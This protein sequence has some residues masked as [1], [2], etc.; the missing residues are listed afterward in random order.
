MKPG[1]RTYHDA[2]LHVRA[3]ELVSPRLRDGLREVTDIYTPPAARRQGQA[4]TLLASVC[5][6][7]DGMG[8]TLLIAVIGTEDASTDDL[9]G[10]YRRHGFHYLQLE[11]V[12]LMTRP[13]LIAQRAQGLL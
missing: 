6:E 9:C 5:S 1:I 3:S 2:S 12:V 4:D 11:P 7:A 10:W 13:P 8:K